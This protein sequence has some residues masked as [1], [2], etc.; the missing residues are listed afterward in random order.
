MKPMHG[1]V[2]CNTHLEEESIGWI[3]NREHH[4]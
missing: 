3:E 1:D 4:H 2:H